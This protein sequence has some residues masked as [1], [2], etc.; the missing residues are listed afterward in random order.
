MSKLKKRTKEKSARAVGI[1]TIPAGISLISQGEIVSGLV[2]CAVGIGLISLSEYFRDFEIP[3]NDDDI[4][5][6][7][8]ELD[9]SFF[10]S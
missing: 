4:V 9:D 6:M 7:V 8:E 5:E 2:V 3:L 10:D 1:S